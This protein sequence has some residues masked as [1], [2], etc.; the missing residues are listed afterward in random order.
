MKASFEGRIATRRLALFVCRAGHGLPLLFL[1]GS[2]FDM[3]LRKAV[4]SSA[5]TDHFEVVAFEPRGLG[6]SDQPSGNWTM[7][8]YADDACALLDAIGWQRVCVVGESFGAMTAMELAIRYP[9]RVAKLCLMA[10]SSGGAGGSSYPIEQFLSLS[11][12]ARAVAALRVHDLRFDALLRDDQAAAE[13]RIADRIAADAALLGDPSN[14]RGYPRLL[15]ARATHDVHARLG[16]ID[17]P[18]IVMSGVHDG[19]APLRNARALADAIAGAQLLSFDGGHSFAFDT[20]RPVE[21]LLT[22]WAPA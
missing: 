4:F 21:Q 18:T 15:A 1:G 8:D 17:A 5:L 12:R 22:C 6:R 16:D 11:P 7:Q 2:N 9:Q 3:R 20:P 10:G 14:A 19:Q 13:A